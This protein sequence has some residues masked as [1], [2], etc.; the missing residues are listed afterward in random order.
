MLRY[1]YTF[2]VRGKGDWRFYLEVIAVA[3]KYQL[4]RLRNKA[5]KKLKKRTSSTHDPEVLME[6]VTV[7]PKY[8]EHCPAIADLTDDIIEQNIGALFRKSSL[9]GMV[10]LTDE[11]QSHVLSRLDAQKQYLYTCRSCGRQDVVS[12]PEPTDLCP[13]PAC[14]MSYDKSD[15]RACWLSD[16][17]Q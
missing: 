16:S 13:G 1:I 5:F 2:K 14:F 11:M 10:I 15:I 9:G 12:N 8:T 6:M 17:S 7:L 3:N 4:Q